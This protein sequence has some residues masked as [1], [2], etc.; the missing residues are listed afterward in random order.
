MADKKYLSELQHGNDILYM[1]DAEAREEIAE[2]KETTSNGTHYIGKL[3]SAVVDGETVTTLD[4]GASPTQVTTDEGIWVSGTPAEGQHKLTNGDQLLIQGTGENQNAT[5]EFIYSGT[6][7]SEYGSTGAL[8]SLAFKDSASGSVTP[9][10]R[11]SESAVTLTGGSTSKLATT[12]IKGVGGTETVHDTPTLNKSAIG[13]ASGWNAGTMF[14]ASYDESNERLTL[15]PG[16]APSLTVTETQ[17]GTSLTAGAEKTVATAAAQETTVATGG[18]DANG[19]GATVATALPTGGT[20]AGQTF[21][22]NAANVT[23]N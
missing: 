18:V 11:N 5:R 17:V 4:D 19:G 3:I 21:T 9:S 23:V 20:A 6:K 10:G 2:L 13:S 8:K 15:T 12:T 22:G 7:F 14:S 16:T 1:K